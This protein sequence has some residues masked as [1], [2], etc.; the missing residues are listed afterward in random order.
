MASGVVIKV[1][2]MNQVIPTAKDENERQGSVLAEEVRIWNT[3]LVGAYLLWQ[4]T[5]G[6]CDAHPS[7]DAPVGILHFIAS[8]ILANPR[9][10]ETVSNRRKN[11]QSYVAGFEDKKQM[12]LLLSLHDRISSRKQLTLSAIDAAIYAGL[13]SWDPE[14]GKLYPHT[15]PK[16]A[17]RGKTIRPS[18]AREG[19]KARILGTWFSEHDAPTIASYLRVIL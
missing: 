1:K 11:L 3:P 17:G 2:E 16:G 6:Y 15:E 7:G 13:L 4:F 14:S 12:D 18:M 5:S 8:A 19:A 10:N 9:L